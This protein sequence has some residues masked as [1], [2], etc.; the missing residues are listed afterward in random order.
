MRPPS[1][2]RLA[3]LGALALAVAG[4][5]SFPSGAAHAQ[6]RPAAQVPR[7]LLTAAQ[8]PESLLLTLRFSAVRPMGERI[9]RLTG[10]PQ[11]DVD[12]AIDE[13]LGDAVGEDRALLS[14]VDRERPVDVAVILDGQN[15]PQFVISLAAGSAPD[16]EDRLST[17]HRA[18]PWTDGLRPLDPN[19]PSG[20][21]QGRRAPRV[22]CSLAMTPRPEES[23]V[24]CAS[25]QDAVRVA[26]PW[27]ARTLSGQDV[28]PQTIS[29]EVALDPIRTRFGDLAR[30]VISGGPTEVERMLTGDPTSPFAS[31]Q[32]R[33][34]LSRVLTPLAESVRAVIDDVRRLG[35]TITL[36]E[37]AAT[38]EFA[39]DAASPTDPTLRGLRDA[40]LRAPEP[41]LDQASRLPAG[42]AVYGVFRLDSGPIAGLAQNL[43]EL[44]NALAGVIP[45][46]PRP[47]QALLRRMVDDLFGPHRSVT[48][49]AG[50][51]PAGSSMMIQRFD[52]A[53]EALSACRTSS[54]M[55]QLMA[56][57]QIQ[58]RV[59]S[60][61]ASFNL[62][63]SLASMFGRTRLL[64]I[65]RGLPRGTT[66]Y[67]TTQTLPA[68]PPSN[69]AR[70]RTISQ[71]CIPNGN[72]V[73]AFTGNDP[74]TAYRQ[75][76]APGA[77][78][79]AEAASLVQGDAATF[80]FYPRSLATLFADTDRSLSDRIAA[81]VARMPDQGSTP[82]RAAIRVSDAQGTSQYRGVIRL[83]RATLSALPM[84]VQDH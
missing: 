64:P 72:E 40:V 13:T 79:F 5:L 18:S 84:I 77:T 58:R 4:S 3:P 52:G 33:P 55:A 43:R 23:R 11:T 16:V 71:L 62:P 26:G 44:G 63:T 31:P 56:R 65:P 60:A 17:S 8:V 73:V 46:L 6:P 10:L 2:S 48:Y 41:S 74:L 34:L 30:M 32:V 82:I 76:S 21:A 20:I 35:I 7:Q 27:L 12:H 61:L 69:T 68:T 37:D 49:M 59:E 83:E 1:A 50:G 81:S 38:M 9:A 19:A 51:G 67:Q 54:T 36:A 22:R 39:V 66:Y 78:R 47:D 70:T 53:A 45:G 80:A 25:S 57:P 28:T 14:V 24:V 15:R 29:M 42:A 75:W